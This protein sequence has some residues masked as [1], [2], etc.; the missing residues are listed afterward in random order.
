MASTLHVDDIALAQGTALG[1]FYGPKQVSKENAYVMGSNFSGVIIAKGEKVT[2]FKIGDEV[3][4]IPG[5]TDEH[6][7]WATYRCLDKKHIRL[8][9]TELS[10]QEVVAMIIAGCVAYGMILYSEIK[11]GD[12]CLV[13]G[14]SGGIG[15]VVVQ[16]L[17][18]KGA[19][20]TSLCSTR[21]VAAVKSN[22]ADFIIDYQK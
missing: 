14:A 5:T 9:P 17:K 10:H 7:S 15:S 2:E 21:N 8:K 6:G 11:K 4:G 16:M 20:V 19:I 13:L 22:G 12:Q 3:I 1:R 18:A